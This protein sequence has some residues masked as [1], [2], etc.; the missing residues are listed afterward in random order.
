VL[1]EIDSEQSRASMSI[2]HQ[3]DVL[4]Y[5]VKNHQSNANFLHYQRMR[6]IS[7]PIVTE[8]GYLKGHTV[9]P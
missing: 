3:H 8:K 2:T 6:G 5:K 9:F 1:S 7:F 4:K